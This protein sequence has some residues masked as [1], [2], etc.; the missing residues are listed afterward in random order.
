MLKWKDKINVEFVPVLGY[1]NYNND[2]KYISEKQQ[3]AILYSSYVTEFVC[4]DMLR[5]FQLQYMTT[6]IF[7]PRV[8]L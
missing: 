4:C 7:F 2:I 3:I 6:F 8:S 5:I 1:I